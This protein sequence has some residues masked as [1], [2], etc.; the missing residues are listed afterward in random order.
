VFQ[1]FIKYHYGDQK[2]ED[3]MGGTYSMDG[4]IESTNVDRKII[5]KKDFR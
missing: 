1:F 3:E 2:E 4:R 5:T